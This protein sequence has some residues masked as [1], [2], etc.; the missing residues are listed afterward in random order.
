MNGG[1]YARLFLL[2]PL[3]W[4][5]GVWAEPCEKTNCYLYPR[6]EVDALGQTG[7]ISVSDIVYIFGSPD[8]TDLTF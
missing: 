7:C 6:A 2:L 8:I 3:L 5:D 4:F 1:V